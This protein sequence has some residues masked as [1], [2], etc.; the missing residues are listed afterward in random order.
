M[1]STIRFS[2]VPFKKGRRVLV[3]IVLIVTS[4]LGGFHLHT[5]EVDFGWAF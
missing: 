2:P 4:L 3:T 5:A 1:R